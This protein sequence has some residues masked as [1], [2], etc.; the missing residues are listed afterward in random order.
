MNEPN[1]SGYKGR[2]IFFK[3]VE[4]DYISCHPLGA[5]KAMPEDWVLLG[6]CDVDV[7]FID[8]RLGEIDIMEKMLE[9]ERAGWRVK[10]QQIL[11]KIQE[12]RCLEHIKTD[13]EPF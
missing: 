7:R 9:K 5:G 13:E 3:S 4:G 2:V 10:E 11:T 6:E 8:S 1:D 12:L